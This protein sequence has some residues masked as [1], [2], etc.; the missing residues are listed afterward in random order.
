MNS[1]LATLPF[2]T[3]T[4]LFSG[5]SLT[6]EEQQNLEVFFKK[7]ATQPPAQMTSKISLSAM[8]GLFVLIIL[9][10]WVWQKRLRTVRKALVIQALKAGVGR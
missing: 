5:H 6:F 10:W 3:M 2:P 1:I 9:A 4:P 8:G 7:S